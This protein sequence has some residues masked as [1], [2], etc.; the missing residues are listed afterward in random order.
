MERLISQQLDGYVHDHTRERP[1]LFDELRRVT[2]ASTS[3]PDMQVG[4]VEGSLL[5]MLAALMGAKRIL[6]IGTFTGY[7]ALCM[8]EALPDGGEVITCDRD[9][10]ATRI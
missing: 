9:P 10:D 1:A 4:R 2:Y 3:N 7:S 8:A 6:E 5:K